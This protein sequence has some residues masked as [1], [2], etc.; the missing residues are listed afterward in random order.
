MTL[1]AKIL[2]KSEIR[3]PWL[4][5]ASQS[6]ATKMYWAQWDSLRLKDGVVFPTLGD[7]I[8]R[9]YCMATIATMKAQT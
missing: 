6:E 1:L 7:A 4:S 3:P 9:L 5:I 2:K 8:R